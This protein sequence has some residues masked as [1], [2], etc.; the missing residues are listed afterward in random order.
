MIISLKEMQLNFPEYKFHLQKSDRKTMIFDIVR[1]KFVALTPEEW[2][3]QHVLHFLVGEKKVPAT[4][5]G[6]ESAIKLF[7]TM[8]RFDIAVFDRNGRAMLVVE[9]KAPTVALTQ[10]VLDQVIRYNMALRVNY[11]ML[12]NGLTHL[13]CK[14]DQ[15]S[16]NIR[17]IED[18]PDFSNLSS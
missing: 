11:L 7:N 6:V 8:K 15:D 17:I 1:K 13:F 12:T 10:D 4:L 5:I 18:L 14:A 3:R 2:V 9:C 16:G